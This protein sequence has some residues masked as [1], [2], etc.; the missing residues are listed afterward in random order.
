LCIKNP[1]QKL[2]ELRR[3]SLLEFEHL[4]APVHPEPPLRAL[5]E[6]SVPGPGAPRSSSAEYGLDGASDPNPTPAEQKPAT[7]DKPVFKEP[8]FS[9][10][11][12]IPKSEEILSP[13]QE[14]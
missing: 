12:T 11:S 3:S 5:P 10:E 1:V 2:E 14:R 4:K 6:H 7:P 9:G 8:D 13:T